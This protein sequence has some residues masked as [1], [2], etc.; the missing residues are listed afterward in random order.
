M[1]AGK[2]FNSKFKPKLIFRSG[3]FVTIIDADI[4]KRLVSF[5]QHAGEI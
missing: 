1:L 3:I 4:G 5:G 2:S